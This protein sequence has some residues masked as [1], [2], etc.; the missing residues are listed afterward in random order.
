MFYYLVIT[1]KFLKFH[2]A[3]RHDLLLGFLYILLL[4]PGHITYNQYLSHFYYIQLVHCIQEKI[5]F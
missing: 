4:L 3:L 1:N 2:I 5:A